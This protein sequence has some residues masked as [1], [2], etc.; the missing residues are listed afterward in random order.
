MGKWLI[1]MIRSEKCDNIYIGSGIDLEKELRYHINRAERYERLKCCYMASY[2]ILRHGSIIIEEIEVFVGNKKLDL[3]ER[4]EEYIIENKDICVNIFS[5][6]DSKK[7]I[8]NNKKKCKNDIDM[9]KVELEEFIKNNVD[10]KVSA[11]Y[12][13]EDGIILAR[14]EDI[15]EMYDIDNNIE[16][17]YKKWMER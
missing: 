14:D 16:E 17:I 3:L 12:S 13:R 5:P 4:V 7:M 11:G 8:C 9:R 1:Y 15:K 6:L 2:E 10:K